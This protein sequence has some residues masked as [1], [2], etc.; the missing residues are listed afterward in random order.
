ME[1]L[2]R[3]HVDHGVDHAI[4]AVEVDRQRAV[5][6]AVVVQVEL[7]GREQIIAALVDDGRRR[8]QAD[9]VVLGARG[10]IRTVRVDEPRILPRVAFPA[11]IPGPALDARVIHG[12]GF[13]TDLSGLVH[14]AR[15]AVAP[16]HDI[17]KRDVA[18]TARENTAA[19]RTGYVG[20][21]RRARQRNR[22]DLVV[23]SAAPAQGLVAA[24]HAVHQLGGAVG[25]EQPT[26]LHIGGVAQNQ[27][28][29]QADI[30]SGGR[31]RTALLRGAV[32]PQGT[33]D[34]HDGAVRPAADGAAEL[35]GVR[36]EGAV[37]EGH[38]T[39]HRVDRPAG[40]N[41]GPAVEA[42]PFERGRAVL[43]VK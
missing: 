18:S 30:A 7:V 4:D 24:D 10:A 28:I 35:R 15:V 26:T 27:A 32:S 1:A 34:Q 21:K 25:R 8:Q 14:T 19:G 42:A 23:E 37:F 16:Q 13:A 12:D 33:A 29:D 9:V 20:G 36:R 3:A 22:P 40:L 5:G 17:G 11:E 38:G 31:Q 43:H 2:V 41:G 39:G 6:V